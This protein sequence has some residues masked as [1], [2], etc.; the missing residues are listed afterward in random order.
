MKKIIMVTPHLSTGGLPQYTLRMIEHMRGDYEVYCV[1]WD[2]I[3]G[4]VF[5][6]QRNKIYE[7]LNDQSGD[8]FLTLGEDK[9]E[10]LRLIDSIG[11]DII[12]FQEIPETFLP[13]DILTAVWHESRNYEI[14]IT[15]HSSYTNPS[16]IRFSAD[17]FILVSEWSRNIFVTE[18]G[19]DICTVWEY[20]TKKQIYD[21]DVAKD[22][23]SFD[24]SKTHLLNVGLFTPGKNQ[25]QII[26][27]ARKIEDN[28][29]IVFHFL[30]N[31]A[32]NFIDYWEPL[33]SDFPSNCVW[34]GERHNVEDFYK[35]ADIFIFPSLFELNPISIKEAISFGLPL[36]LR[37]LETYENSYNDISYFIGDDN[38]KCLDTIYKAIENNNLHRKSLYDNIKINDNIYRVTDPTISVDYI[39][40]PKVTIT[41]APGD[42]FIVS[43][44]DSKT[45]VTHYI[46][47][48]GN[49]CWAKCNIRYAIEWKI[50]AVRKSD[51]RVFEENFDPKNKKVFITLE[52]KSIG[53]TLAW[54]PQIEEFRKKWNCDIICS[55][56]WNSEFIENYKDIK[57]IEP[58]SVAHG[59]YAMY[60]I[61][62]FFDGESHLNT[63]H[64]RDFKNLPLT[65]TASD[66]LGLEHKQ[67]KATLNVDNVEKSKTVGIGFHSTA[68]TKYWNNPTGW[69]ELTN[70]LIKMGYE[71]IILSNDGDGYMG[72][73][74]PNGVSILPSGDFQALKSA[75]MS[76]EFFVGIGS[77]LSWL[78]WTL[79]IPTVLISGFSKPISEFYGDN[80]IRIFNPNTCNSCYNRYRFNP[81][82]WNW[83]PDHKDTE[84]Q[85]ECT[86]SITGNMVI[87]KI[88]ERGWISM[89]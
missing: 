86:K 58:G 51:G 8:R 46:T 7:I 79:D 25:K 69:Q 29:N 84:R 32:D 45:G 71:V 83:C 43:F 64:P 73:F 5:V 42:V 56:F 4:G 23:L 66:I 40:G 81:G 70:F 37:N 9:Y 61:G 13:N 75:M 72:N 74:Y 10:F 50:S 53:D 36:I 62:W 76:C 88:I 3:T 82:D 26:E 24:K 12:H 33:M 57:F 2:N 63:S 68:Q 35:A 80:V 6:V 22:K 65:Q 48:I 52:S 28:T 44:I 15:T 34:H 78:A 49:G 60:N 11:P 67:I 1:E 38:D 16:K 39:N 77:G 87:S 17:R 31:Q 20:P 55:T 14:V 47:E 85:F 41:D 59:I 27:I 19:E 89:I 18:F 21:K 54:F 30:G